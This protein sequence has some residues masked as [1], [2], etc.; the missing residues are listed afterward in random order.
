MDEV[1]TLE[2]PSTISMN[3]DIPAL[4]SEGKE[5]GTLEQYTKTNKEDEFKI[6]NQSELNNKEA[7]AI[8][9]V[10]SSEEAVKSSEENSD[11]E[12]IYDYESLIKKDHNKEED[13][14]QSINSK[15]VKSK[16]EQNFKSLNEGEYKKIYNIKLIA[17]NKRAINDFISMKFTFGTYLNNER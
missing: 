15:S 1:Y 5:D 6:K 11:S 14:K 3:D 17:P 4:E 9:E 16:V 13:K 10:S 12:E 8:T 7:D 2:S